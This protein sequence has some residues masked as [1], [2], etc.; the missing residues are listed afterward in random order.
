MAAL[1]SLLYVIVLLINA[2][3]VLS[4]DRF[5]ARINWSTKSFDPAFGQAG[6]DTSVKGKIVSLIASVR[7]IMRIPLIIT[8]TLIIVYELILG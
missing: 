5:L 7:M 8:N 4:E 2:L 6:S 3:A 1:G